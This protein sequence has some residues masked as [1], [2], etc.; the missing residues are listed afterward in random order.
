MVAG[1]VGDGH[2]I[3]GSEVDLGVVYTGLAVRTADPI[4]QVATATGLR[5]ALRHA[6]TIYFPD[7]RVATAGIHFAKVM[8]QLG[9]TAELSPRV[10]TYPNGHAAMT[11]MAVHAGGNPI[12]CTQ[13]TEILSVNGVTPAG[14][15]PHE[16]EL[17]TVYTAALTRR[18]AQPNAAGRLAGSLAGPAADA[19][20]ERLG[21]A[22][23]R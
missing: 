11:A 22:P 19:L 20:R 12:G 16:F 4:P 18:A 9:V 3:A 13:I 5:D 17:A 7:P 15:L 2:L 8:H 23:A 6:D 1:L 10:R 14:L 21:F